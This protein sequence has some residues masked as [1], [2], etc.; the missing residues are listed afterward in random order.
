MKPSDRKWVPPNAWLAY[1]DGQNPRYPQTALGSDFVRIRERVAGIRNDATTPDTRLADDPMKFNPASIQS[2]VHLMTGGLY[3]GKNGMI[4]Q[5]RLRYFDPKRQRA[6]IAEDVAALIEKMT[7]DTVTVVLVNVNQLDARTVVVQGGAY[8]EHQI[9]AAKV[10]GKSIDIGDSSFTVKLQP[11]S[12][13]RMV[14]KMKRYANQPTLA[15][16]WNR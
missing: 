12:G 6:G 15:F 11:G 13:S 1:L 3:S 10:D 9:L 4:H 16:P 8:A 14:L 2:L 5:C 7:D